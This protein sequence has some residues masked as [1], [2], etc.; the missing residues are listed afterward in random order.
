MSFGAQS[1]VAL[2]DSIALATAAAVGDCDPLIDYAGRKYPTVIVDITA[3]RVDAGPASVDLATRP[4]GERVAVAL[5]MA[6]QIVEESGKFT[7]LYIKALMHIMGI[8]GNSH[9]A[10]LHLQAAFTWSSFTYDRHLAHPAVAPWFWIEPTGLS[11]LPAS[12]YPAVAA[13]YGHYV[14]PGSESEI[15]L[16]PQA[17]LVGEDNGCCGVGFEW[18]SARTV[19]ALLHLNLHHQDGL[20]NMIVRQADHNG[21]FL[22]GAGAPV[23]NR[24]RNGQ[25]A[26]TY[27]WGR[28]HSMLPHPAEAIYV[29]GHV[30][31][32][33]R[34]FVYSNDNMF[35]AVPQHMFTS[36]ELLHGS[37]RV[38]VTRPS[39]Q[40]THSLQVQTRSVSKLRTAASDALRLARRAF[41]YDMACKFMPQSVTGIVD[42]YT[43]S[44]TRH[45]PVLAASV[46]TQQPARGVGASSV[47]EVGTP[48]ATQVGQS[49]VSAS[50]EQQAEQ[51]TATARGPPV[52]R[53]I[54]NVS[55]QGPQRAQEQQRRVPQVPGGG[56]TEQ[57]SSAPE[58]Q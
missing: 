49:M 33:F 36:T 26:A 52:V 10:E 44:V 6:N 56:G 1:F 17:R 51:S 32:L 47:H 29:K 13:G 28:G 11:R 23:A 4:E 5:N 9:V 50:D 25:D 19:G 18:R 53:S 43:L 20:A 27:M 30:R 38:R 35:T 58:T 57:V 31:A 41:G 22:V 54:V 48:N 8:G 16:L 2:I 14:E 15:A 37:V 42:E 12:E 46:V 3:E 24:I 40:G 39:T 7:P 45:D 21:F 34:S 55:L